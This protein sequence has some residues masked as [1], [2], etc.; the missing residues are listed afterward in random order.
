MHVHMP[1][2]PQIQPEAYP[3]LL[4]PFQLLSL[5]L[6][7]LC[8]SSAGASSHASDGWEAERAAALPTPQAYIS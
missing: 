1:F 7:L 8:L 4:N 6:L 5:P 2:S 3:L